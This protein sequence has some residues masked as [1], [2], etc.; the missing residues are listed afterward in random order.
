LNEPG[1]VGALIEAYVG[2]GVFGAAALPAGKAGRE[3]YRIVWFRNQC[4][5]LDVDTRRARASMNGVLPSIEPRSKLDRALRAWLRS[6]QAPDLPAHRRLDPAQF[7]AG[8][9]NAGGA[10]QLNVVSKSNDPTQAAR[11]LLTLVNEIYLDFL[12]TPE[13]YDWVNEAFDLDPDN[14]RWP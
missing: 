7:Q 13:R 8:L 6:R 12:A 10:V 1:S 2:R 4:M 9:R 11:R 5:I 3:S 14:P